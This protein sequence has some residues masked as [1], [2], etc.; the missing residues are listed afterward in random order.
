MRIGGVLKAWA[1]VLGGRAPILSIE[2][3]R[4]CP[5]RCP[6]CYA[7][8]DAHLGG[9]TTLRD[10]TDLRGTALVDGILELVGRHRP[11]QVSLVG[12]EP[13][14]RHRELSVVLPQLSRLGVYTLVVTSGVVRIP[15]EWRGIPRLRVGVSVDGLP[16]HHDVR[17]HPAT[18][19]RILTHIEGC[20]VDVSWVVTQPMLER[21]GYLDEYLAF[22]TTRPEIDRVAMS[23]YTPQVGENSRETLTPEA[24]TSLV[25]QLADLKRRYPALVLTDEMLRGFETPP[26]SPSECAFSRLSVNYSA[27]LRT[28]VEPCVFGGTPDC[29]R[30]GCA[31]TAI[32][33]GVVKKRLLG[34][35]S[36]GSIL[37]TSIDVGSLVG[38]LRGRPTLASRWTRAELET[39]P[40]HRVSSP[41]PNG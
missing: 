12:G 10:L 1:G 26:T 9:D 25:G 28:R 3:T 15:P 23:L 40:P 30:C 21:A 11:V 35:V 24:R 38:R 41:R 14:V 7:Y 18:Y 34:L 31:A 4:E 5:L 13:L 29:R 19:E 27:D 33:G 32:V 17:R 6:G 39:T 36:A 20:R 22:W 8:G 37:N 2:I 16:E